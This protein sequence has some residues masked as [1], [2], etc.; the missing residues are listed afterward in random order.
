VSLAAIPPAAFRFFGCSR[1]RS[2]PLPG[3]SRDVLRAAACPQPATNPFLASAARL[4]RQFERRV[5]DR[6]RVACSGSNDGPAV[7]SGTTARAE[8]QEQAVPGSLGR[9]DLSMTRRWRALVVASVALVVAACPSATAPSSVP[10]SYVAGITATPLPSST[11]APTLATSAV[12]AVAASPTETQISPPA[13][14]Q[15]GSTPVPQPLCSASQLRAAVSV[16]TTAPGVATGASLP[17]MRPRHFATCAAKPKP[18]WSTASGTSSPT[19][20]RR[21]RE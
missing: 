6:A 18:R 1:R 3:E 10:L 14:A 9:G 8:P 7:R 19:R 12:P 11:T 16:W 21:P 13:S 5:A 15:T 20:A 4:T 2:A 17:R